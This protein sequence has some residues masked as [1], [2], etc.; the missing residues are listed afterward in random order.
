VSLGDRLRLSA[1]RARDG[2]G[3]GLAGPV[4]AR[5]GVDAPQAQPDAA[6]VPGTEPIGG[7]GDRVDPWREQPADAYDDDQLAALRDELETELSRLTR[8]QND[9]APGP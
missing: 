5:L 1:Q 4:L 8:P 6:P 2:R 7:K 3:G 9:E